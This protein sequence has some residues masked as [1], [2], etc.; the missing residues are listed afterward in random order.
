MTRPPLTLGKRAPLLVPLPAGE[1]HAFALPGDRASAVLVHGFTS[2]PWEVRCVGDA[3][4]SHGIAAHGVLLPGHGTDPRDLDGVAHRA[5]QD[6]VREA[7]LAL[8][9]TKPRFVVG[10]SMGGL[11]AIVLAAEQGARVDGLVLLAPALELFP[12]GVLGGALARAG[13]F[14]RGRTI[15]KEGQGG[16]I[17]DP[18]ARALNPTYPVMSWPG[19]GEFDRLRASA[20]R[21]LPRVV[22]PTLVLHGAHDATVKPSGAR[23]VSAFAR[24]PIVDRE[25]LARSK[26]IIGVDHEREHVA[27]RTLV[28][29][30][31]LLAAQGVAGQRP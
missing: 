29:L 11:L 18:A 16:D 30:E 14:R 17:G 28:F 25:V 2:T 26:H 10:S 3:L 4:S 8:D 22:S 1:P 7:F 15:P 9:D 21:A 27:R 13:L 24:A 19:L 23:L 20:R 12:T 31:R 5:W 6:A